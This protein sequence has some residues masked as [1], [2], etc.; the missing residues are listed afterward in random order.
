MGGSGDPSDD[1]D[2][3]LLA[4]ND[5][6][7]SISAVP[8]LGPIRGVWVFNDVVYAFRDNVGATAGDMY[9]STASGWSQ[10]TF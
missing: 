1:A 9:K 5:L 7:T 4:A 10:V 3:T 8:R 6:R 2:Y